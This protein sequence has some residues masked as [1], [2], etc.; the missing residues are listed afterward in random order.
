MAQRACFCDECQ[1]PVEQATRFDLLADGVRVLV[2]KGVDII[3]TQTQAAAIAAKSITA[4]TPIVF[5]GVRDPVVAGLVVSINHP[6][7]NATGVT[8][9][10]STELVTKQVELFQEIAPA[11]SRLGVLFNPTNIIQREVLATITAEMAKRGIET[12]SYGLAKPDEM[13][14]A[15][16]RMASNNIDGLMTLVDPLLFE[17]RAL[18]AALA[19][20]KRIPTSFEV[21][22]YVDAGGLFC[23]GLPYLDHWA[24]GTNYVATILNGTPRR[25]I[26]RCNCQVASRL[27]SIRRQLSCWAWIFRFLFSFERLKFWN[28]LILIIQTST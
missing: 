17:Q 9:T 21:R 12:S 19:I 18:L 27:F 1:R 26:C 11:F 8:L 2:D 28:S 20:E 22:E 3:A 5:M 25:A 10:T 15:F 24:N 14:P 13:R 16:D 23:Y 6:G 4:T 7:S